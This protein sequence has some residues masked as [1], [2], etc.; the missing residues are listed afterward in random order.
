MP[1]IVCCSRCQS[2]NVM[3]SR[4]RNLHVCEDCGHEFSVEKPFEPLRIFLSYG[5]DSNGVK[6]GVRS[7]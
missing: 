1:E 7:L 2:Q 6:K 4:K 3:F 5:H